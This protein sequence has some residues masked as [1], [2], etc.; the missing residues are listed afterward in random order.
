MGEE[1]ISTASWQTN[2][3][4]LDFEQV[5]VDATSGGVGL[6]SSKYAP[7]GS[8][9]RNVARISVDTASIKVTEDGTAP[10]ASLGDTYAAG[11]QFI[12]SGV[13]SL[14]KLR[15]I[16]TTSTSGVINVTYYIARGQN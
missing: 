16:R 10:T 1:M 8:P 4:A 12:V 11:D 14:R 6:T 2:V 15:M 3:E 13:N 5:T 9:P 7:S